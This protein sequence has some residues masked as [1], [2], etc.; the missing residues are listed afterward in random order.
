MIGTILALLS[1]TAHA[2]EF[3][4]QRPAV[5]ETGRCTEIFNATQ[6]HLLL[7]LSSFQVKTYPWNPVVRLSGEA[8]PVMR[9]NSSVWLVG[10]PPNSLVRATSWQVKEK[11][12]QR[13]TLVADGKNCLAAISPSTDAH[14]H[15]V[16]GLSPTSCL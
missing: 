6:T 1:T 7:D 3:F 12:R 11:G 9:P 2:R 14:D 4:F 10:E 16:F 13:G 15:L 8:H 5:C